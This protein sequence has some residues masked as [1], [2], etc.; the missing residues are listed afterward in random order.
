MA[1]R[2]LVLDRGWLTEQEFLDTLVL[3]RLS[4]GITI[5]AQAL[6]IGKR[7]AGIRGLLAAVTGLV[8]PAVAITIGLARGYQFVA[9]LPAAS[10]PLRCIAGVAAGFAVALAFQLLRDMLRRSH[11]WLGPVAV[12]GYVALSLTI[13]NPI[14]LLVTAIAAGVAL[15]GLFP[16]AGSDP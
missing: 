7:V 4:P 15:P 12:A 1:M 2:R 8:L 5:I 9:T 10:T 13:G 16:S 11:R 14:V 3:S 6:L